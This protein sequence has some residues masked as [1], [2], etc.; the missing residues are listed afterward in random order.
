MDGGIGDI[1]VL[2]RYAVKCCIKN[3]ETVNS[4]VKV[5]FVQ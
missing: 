3:G 5:R 2:D 4:G 1:G